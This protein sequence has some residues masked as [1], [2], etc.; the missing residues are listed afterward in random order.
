MKFTLNWLKDHLDTTASLNE[1]TD[2]LTSLGL[3]VESVTD[4][5]KQLSPFK[6]AKILHAEQHP[7]A[8]RLRVCKVDT[9]TEQLQ[10]V[11]GAPNARA[12]IS[13]VLAPIGAVIPTNG[14]V[15]KKSAIRGVESNGMLCSAE[16]LGL[17]TDGEGIV[18]LQ[19]EPKPGTA[20]APAL[21]FED[22]VIEIAIT[23]NRADCLGVRGIARDLA[24]KGLGKLKDA[25]TKKQEAKTKSPV[26]VKLQATSAP[27]Y[28]GR[29]FTNVKNGE[30]PAWLKNRLQMIGQKPI[31]ALV[32]ITN[33]ITFDLGRPLHVS[34][35]AKIGK[36]IIISSPSDLPTK[37]YEFKEF[38]LLDGRKLTYN[39]S[40]DGRPIFSW[41]KGFTHFNLENPL[42]I[43]DDR[44]A[45]PNQEKYRP[46]AIAGI[47]G[48]KDTGV[49]ET[50]T[51]VFL[52][53]AY[54]E[55]DTIRK[56]GQALQID[57]DAKYRFERRVDPEFLQEGAEIAT[58][59]ILELCGGETSELVVAGKSPY[60][61]HTIAF[62]FA[63]TE[64]LSGVKVA[65][66]EAEKILASL[67]I[68]RNGNAFQIPSTR[69]D[70]KAEADLVEEILRVKGYDSIP[71]T[72]LPAT[73]L[74][75]ALKPAQRL[76]GDMRRLLAM[77]GMTEAV[78]FSFMHSKKVEIKPELMLLNPISAELD[79]MRPSI[80]PNLIDAYQKNA[81]RGIKN[82]ALFEIGPVY[83]GVLPEQNRTMITGLRTGDTAPKN[84]YKQGRLVD[85]FDAKADLFALLGLSINPEKVTLETGATA[86][87]HPG[88]SATLKLGQKILGYFG[89]LH[90]ALGLEEAAIG[91]E[92]YA[93]AVPAPNRKIQKPDISDLQPVTRDFAFVVDQNVTA[94]ALLKAVK[95]AD[96]NLIREVAIF[97]IYVGKG[98]TE[99]T[100]SIAISVTLQPTQKTL[101]AAEIE[102][103][104]QAIIAKAAKD[105]AATLRA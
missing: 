83:E 36:N 75:A 94:E 64:S 27:Y 38:E 69:D 58:R 62:D 33:Y 104:A 95:N 5:S 17:G 29:Y 105:C 81:A 49:S 32:D 30:S 89:E 91:F 45:D 97:D 74:K 78:T 13:V 37:L 96:K 56:M 65:K 67:G 53:V 102:A 80:L 31:S 101:E 4:F 73:E 71:L 54:F 2:A 66:E 40:E 21:G 1:I 34:D 15:I 60:V 79:G 100:K 57:S 76:L 28:V 6:V 12:G 55:P 19:G 20:A 84:L 61:P 87:Y 90:P 68:T 85:A 42:I 86:Q 18:E 11:C 77:R 10:I 48:G 98:L 93:D 43:F 72:P 51:E 25:P 14:L 23:P 26:T 41:G 92:L 82:V 47:I 99:G 63:K 16:E 59:M 22:A 8:D 9:G 3:E 39:L 70:I 7:Q 52:E 50:T 88:R 103:V 44:R 35:V 24:A 46:I